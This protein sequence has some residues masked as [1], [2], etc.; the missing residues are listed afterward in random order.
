MIYSEEIENEPLWASFQRQKDTVDGE[1]YAL[2]FEYKDADGKI[3]YC[4]NETWIIET[5]IPLSLDKRNAELSNQLKV[6][7]EKKD[8][9]LLRKLV[10][11][12]MR[13]GWI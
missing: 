11:E 3:A 13:L 6:N 2:A 8:F 4:D 5:L 12:I 9:K 1:W 10:K 7:W